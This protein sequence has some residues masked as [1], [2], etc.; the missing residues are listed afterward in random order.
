MDNEIKDLERW[1]WYTVMFLNHC[2]NGSLKSKAV[3][4][5]FSQQH[6]LENTNNF[7]TWNQATVLMAL[8]GLFVVPKEFWRNKGGSTD[9][10]KINSDGK[11]VENFKFE[12]RQTF[13]GDDEYIKNMSTAVFFRRFRNSLAHANFEFDKKHNILTFKN[14][15]KKNNIN[16]EVSNNMC[17]LSEFLT[18][19]G[20]Y[21]INNITQFENNN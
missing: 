12:S 5:E 4:E 2:Q 8:Y 16:F 9:A 21:F 15:D 7:C 6:D 1:T 17:G 14:F 10:E 20:K 18:E 3:L 19:I 13:K 11:I